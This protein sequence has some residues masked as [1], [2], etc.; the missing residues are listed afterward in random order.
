[1]EKGFRGAVC[2]E[3]EDRAY[4]GTFEARKASLVQSYRY[5]KNFLP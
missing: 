3:V 4:E 5:L 1:M 2:V